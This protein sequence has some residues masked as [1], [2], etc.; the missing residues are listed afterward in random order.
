MI[1]EEQYGKDGWWYRLSWEERRIIRQ[2]LY[3]LTDGPLSTLPGKLPGTWGGLI[4]IVGP[5]LV[6]RIRKP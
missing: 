5:E 1:P 2:F 4:S 3:N 6:T